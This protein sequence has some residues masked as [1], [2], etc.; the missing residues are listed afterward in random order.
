MFRGA[1]IGAGEQET[2]LRVEAAARPHLLPVDDPAFPVEHGAGREVREVGAG[3]GLGEQLAPDLGAGA[4]PGEPSALLGSGR[5]REQHRADEREADEVRVQVGRVEPA[6]LLLHDGRLG[7]GRGEPAELD[8]PGRDRP[9]AV[10]CFEEC[11]PGDE[12]VVARSEHGA[13]GR[14]CARPEPGLQRATSRGAE[15]LERRS[16]SVFAGAHRPRG[17]EPVP[18]VCRVRR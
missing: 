10:H 3:V 4:D 1:G 7:C 11:A 18:G 5:V 9:A 16:L 2:T 15:R 13:G 12:V 14:G 6:Q 17:Y 8:R